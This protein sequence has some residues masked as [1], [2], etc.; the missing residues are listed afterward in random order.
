M[1]EAAPQSCHQYLLFDFKKCILNFFLILHLKFTFYTF[2]GF[3]STGCQ[4]LRGCVSLA[5][6]RI[7]WAGTNK[8]KLSQSQPPL[9]KCLWETLCDT[10]ARNQMGQRNA[11]MR[12]LITCGDFLSED[13]RIR[14][15]DYFWSCLRRDQYVSAAPTTTARKIS[16]INNKKKLIFVMVVVSN[17]S[18][19]AAL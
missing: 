17:H 13:G 7:P 5:L 18:F 9:L 3:F 12:F 8:G 19:Q 2:K 4:I 15:L 10:G 16:V 11:E 6:D 14:W 1:D